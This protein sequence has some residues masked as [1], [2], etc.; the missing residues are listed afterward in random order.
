MPDF[1]VIL[2]ALD[3]FITFPGYTL[4]QSNATLT[5]KVYTMVQ[6]LNIEEVVQSI[7]REAL[8][9]GSYVGMGTPNGL[10]PLEDLRREFPQATIVTLSLAEILTAVQ[11]AVRSENEDATTGGSAGSA[12]R[13]L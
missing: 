4:S 8:E 12:S 9:E 2:P 6:V 5:R 10:E 7:L 1:T 3:L 11:E 13:K